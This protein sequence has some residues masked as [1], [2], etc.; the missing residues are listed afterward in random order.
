M[1]EQLGAT[2]ENADDPDKPLVF[3]YGE[4]Y[5]TPKK[6]VEDNDNV[7]EKKEEPRKIA[8]RS[9]DN[10]LHFRQSNDS[11]DFISDDDTPE[12]DRR[13][14]IKLGNV[15][16]NIFAHIRTAADIEPQLRQLEQE[17]VIYSDEFNAYD[18][19]RSIEKAL[20][21]PQ[22]KD[23]FSPRWRLYNECTI[24]E[25]DKETKTKIEHRPDR[26]MTDGHQWIVVDFK[27]GHRND[28]DYF[29]QVGGYMDIIRRMGAENVIGYIWYVMRDEVVPVP[30]TK[31][32]K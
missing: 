25:Y 30:F 28:T 22:V 10:P 32:G 29:R 23:W 8:I 17:G 31:R 2:I 18:L 19:R 3:T 5:I 6:A 26:V 4:L 1:A 21:N 24:L 11:R 13:R 7:F 20:A 15:L 14:Y 27:F 12:Q 9:Y 16:H